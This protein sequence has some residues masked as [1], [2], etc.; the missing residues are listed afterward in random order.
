MLVNWPERVFCNSVA[1]RF[2]LKRQLGSL[3]AMSGLGPGARCLEIG[4]GNGNGALHALRAF[5]PAQYHAI[6]LDPDMLR[7]AAAKARNEQR[8]C[9]LRGDA[10]ALPFRDAS[11]DAVFNLGIIHHL[12]DWRRGLAEV[13][14]VLVPGGLFLFEEIYPA[15]YA[16]PI[17]RDVLAHPRGD[18]FDG[19]EFRRELALQ[20]LAL[21]PG[22][23]ESRFTILGVARKAHSVS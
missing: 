9:L 22:Y 7:L 20:A 4:C 13:S 11:F 2:I 8:L 3:K 6:D 14:R 17:L 18:R 21:Q 10:Q 12:E 5:E 1:R 23:R 19:R 15:L 16:A